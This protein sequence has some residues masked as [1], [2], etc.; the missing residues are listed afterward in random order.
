MN[1]LPE[2]KHFT[3]KECADAWGLTVQDLLHMELTVK[4]S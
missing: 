1:P 3:A 4:L 2:K